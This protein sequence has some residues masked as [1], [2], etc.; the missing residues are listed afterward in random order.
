MLSS[1][2]SKLKR[3]SWNGVDVNTMLF[4]LCCVNYLYC[5]LLPSHSLY[6]AL[7][8]NISPFAL[9]E[10][11]DNSIHCH[12][13]KILPLKVT[14]KSCGSSI[15]LLFCSWLYAASTFFFFLLRGTVIPVVILLT[16]ITICHKKGGG[17]PC[18]L[19]ILFITDSENLSHDVCLSSTTK[20]DHTK[21]VNQK[22]FKR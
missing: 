5:T 8:I 12:C 15:L 10:Y 7:F 9:T 19:W 2:E 14:V 16:N 6:S 11:M 17:Q 22:I 18:S 21:W 4:K 1:V 13:V 3:I 20:R